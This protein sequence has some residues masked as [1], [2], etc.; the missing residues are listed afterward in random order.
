MYQ[1]SGQMQSG[2]PRPFVS[3][4]DALG[5]GW[6][7]GLATACC[8][9]VA[10]GMSSRC[11]VY[12]VNSGPFLPQFAISCR[13]HFAQLLLTSPVQSCMPAKAG[14]SGDSELANHILLSDTTTA[15]G[16]Q[17]VCV[18]YSNTRMHVE[19]MQLLR[20]AAHG[21]SKGVAAMAIQGG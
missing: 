12:G 10:S 20:A 7:L 17:T 18:R 8:V 1:A 5:G 21:G 6:V 3:S 13:S 4:I 2:C 9:P 19:D 11:T 15:R 14:A 16:C